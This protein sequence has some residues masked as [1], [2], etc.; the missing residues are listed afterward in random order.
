[1]TYIQALAIAILQGATELFPVS[2][3]GHAVILPSLLKSS[4]DQAS[5]AFLP[6]VVMLH[7]GTAVAL[8]QFFWRDWWLI[9]TGV[10]GLST[11]H[12]IKESRRVFLLIVIATIP[13]VIVALLFEKMIRGLF[14]APLIAAGF[15][16]VNGLILLVGERLRGTGDRPLTDIKPLD[17]FIIGCA[18]CLA[19][20]PGIS[21]SGSTIVAGL[22][23]GINHESSAHFS[24]L[25]ATPI[26]FGA[27]VH[28][29]PKLLHATMAPGA[30][31][32]AT[33]AA[34]VSGLTAWLSTWFLM[35]YFR[36][37]ENWALNP[38]GY[39]CLA[40]GLGS[41]LWLWL[42]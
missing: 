3:L 35:R 28:Q 24:F 18:Q 20:I 42:A 13:A 22:L 7:L 31:T 16:A 41:S 8:L 1:V 17:A 6:F 19:L 40:F 9:G 21:R 23:R 36:S 39:Y 15:L 27:T 37:N 2:S 26:I 14:A 5:E 25:I 11:P 38:F 33:V 29:A 4:I 10:I 30:F 12:Q 34:I 32:M